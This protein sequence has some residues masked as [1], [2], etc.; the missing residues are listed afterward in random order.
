MRSSNDRPPYTDLSFIGALSTASQKE[1]ILD[2]PHNLGTSNSGQLTLTED[3][4]MSVLFVR[5]ARA[6]VLGENLFSDPAWDILLELFAAKLGRRQM[7]LTE[8]A[9][10]IETPVST[11]SRWLAALK[12]QGLVQS[13]IQAADPHTPLLKLTDEGASR[14]ERLAG[15]WASA[16]VSF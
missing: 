3:H 13:D 14:M 12:S 5:R 7:T 4:L 6:A 16:F 9:L 2:F 1:H 8:I 11:T 15:Q 10:S